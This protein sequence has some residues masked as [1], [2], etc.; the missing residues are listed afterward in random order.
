MT[1]SSSTLPVP[2]TNEQLDLTQFSEEQRSAVESY[3]RS[4]LAR[5]AVIAAGPAPVST[6]SP[7]S[8]DWYVPTAH[9]AITAR[10]MRANRDMP[11]ILHETPLPTAEGEA[12]VHVSI[13]HKG[14]YFRVGEDQVFV[15]NSGY[16]YS[17]QKRP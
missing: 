15:T 5:A 16:W 4:V 8:E 13:G 14:L 2:L 10:A 9:A 7:R 6:P 11:K 12:E 3:T 17:E 1:E